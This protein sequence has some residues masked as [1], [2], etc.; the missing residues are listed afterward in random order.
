[1]PTITLLE[2]RRNAQRIIRAVHRGQRYVL[3]VRGKPMAR[4]EPPEPELSDSPESAGE[5]PLFGLHALSTDALPPITNDEIDA[6]L[7]KP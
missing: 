7:G 5:D 4:L 1:M 6:T 2:L 3:T